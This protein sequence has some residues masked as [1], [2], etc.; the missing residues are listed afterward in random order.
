MHDKK[1]TMA[2]KCTSFTGRF[3]GL[4]NPPLQYRTHHPMEDVLGYIRGH[5][6][7]PPGDYS[8]RIA[9]AAARVIGFI[10]HTKVVAVKMAIPKQAAKRHNMD[11]V[12]TS[13]MPQ[14]S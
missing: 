10:T 8:H 2:N 12:L 11:P 6:T 14:A 5:W 3:D 13:S 1:S 4:G 7:L 9:P